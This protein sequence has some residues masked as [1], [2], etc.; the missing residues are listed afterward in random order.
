[1]DAHQPVTL[2]EGDRYPLGLPKYSEGIVTP[3]GRQIFATVVQRIGHDATNV[4]IGVRFPTVVPNL[5][6]CRIMAL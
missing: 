2:K 4:K 3:T 6:R 5:F 1:M